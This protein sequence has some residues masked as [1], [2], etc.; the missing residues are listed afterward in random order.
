M[1]GSER[2]IDT[3]K[4]R[5]IRVTPQRAI[6]LAAIEQMPGHVTAEEIYDNVQRVNS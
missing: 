2:L 3:L 6:I 5:G 4:G 1:A